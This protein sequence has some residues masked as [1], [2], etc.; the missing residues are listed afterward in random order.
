MIK[1]Y[2]PQGGQTVAKLT[3]DIVP[4][5]HWRHSRFKFTLDIVIKDPAL[6]D[7]V[8]TLVGKDVGA[9]VGLRVGFVGEAVGARVGTT[10]GEAVGVRVGHCV[11]ILVGTN[12]I[13]IYMWEMD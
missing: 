7:T 3:V 10:V 1:L 2:E 9:T 4:A 6:Q 11:G 8:G 13:I 12:I 5:S